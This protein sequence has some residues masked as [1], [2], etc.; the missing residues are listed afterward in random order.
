MLSEAQKE[1]IMLDLKPSLDDANQYYESYL[2]PKYLERQNVLD[3]TAE[4]YN[5]KYPALAKMPLTTS[6]VYDT[7]M[8]IM[9]ALVE[10]FSASDEVVCIQGQNAEDDTR[11]K[12]VQEL[13]NYQV[14]RLNDG[15]M[16]RYYWMLSALAMNIGFM[17]VSWVQHR[18]VREKRAVLNE[19]GLWALEE[20]PEVTI[21]ETEV[22]SQG[23]GVRVTTIYSVKYE[24]TIVTENRPLVECL[25]V[26]EVQWA[27]NAK[28]LKEAQFVKHKVRRTIDYLNRKQREGVYFDI[29]KAKEETGA[30]VTDSYENERRNYV[31]EIDYGTD[32]LRREITIDECYCQYPLAENFEATDELHDWIFT[33]AGERVLIGAQYNNMGRRH[34]IIELLAMPDP[35]NVVPDK[36]I[37][38]LLAEIQHINVAMTR[39]VVRHLLVSNE[40]RRFVNKRIVDQ[41][42]LINEAAD[43]GVEGSPREA[44]M[45]MPTTALSPATMPFLEYMQSRLRRTI[46]V[47]EYNTGTDAK[48]L[49]PTATGV[50]AIIEQANKKIKLIA[51][52]MAETG[53]VEMYRFLI[54]LNQQYPSKKQYIRLLNEDI[55]I[56]SSDLEGKLDLVVNVGL[57]NTNKQQEIEATQL[58][59]A[60]LEKLG[61][62]FPGM[63]T[64]DKAYNLVK[65]LLEQ[66]GRKNVDE[67]INSPE[68]MRKFAA[69]QGQDKNAAGEELTK[70]VST[71]FRDMPIPAQI[72]IMQKLGLM[73]MPE[74]YVEDARLK[75]MIEVQLKKGGEAFGNQRSAARTSAGPNSSGASGK[76]GIAVPGVV[77]GGIGGQ[78]PARNPN[79][80]GGGTTAVPGSVS[81][82]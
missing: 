2:E 54:A 51:R 40:G 63:V 57:G 81:G 70:H 37:I 39:L 38:E 78:V 67:Y 5:Q 20:N 10:I 36:G 7:I 11:A 21:S 72:Q 14:E 30:A 55:E 8:W 46:G 62:M 22:V 44:V 73:V 79:R 77:D 69:M 15:F 60:T 47:S 52:V 33:V 59:L 13:I 49:N 26:T 28:R 65:L 17:K 16:V 74:D 18:E 35:W 41:D 25:P 45:A 32:D 68:V 4:Y 42:D 75:A 9:P 31:K 80:A 3:A 82:V 19:Q 66:M 56:D 58:I 53:Y 64:P 29:D 50:T 23:D 1:Q 76:N 43:I 27:S 71:A 34:P 61:T 6:E 12:K 24:E 48:A